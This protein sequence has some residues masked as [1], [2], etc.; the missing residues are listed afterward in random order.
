MKK[1]KNM[2]R[3]MLALSSMLILAISAP[4][5]MATVITYDFQGILGPI[6][7][8]IFADTETGLSATGDAISG[9]FSFDDGLK[10]SNASNGLDAYRSDFPNDP[11]DALAGGFSASITVGSVTRNHTVAAGGVSPAAQ[12]QV[13]D[14]ANQDRVLFSLGGLANNDPMLYLQAVDNAAA[15]PGDPDGVAAGSNNLMAGYNTIA[16]AG[17]LDILDNLDLSLFDTPFYSTWTQPNSVE[18]TGATGFSKVQFQWTGISRATADVP[19][20]ATL[21]LLGVGLFGLGF[22]RRKQR[23]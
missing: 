1:E 21:A 12:L 4:S 13:V 14:L 8:G 20:P 6:R 18:G 15:N 17:I 7:T 10:D 9:S 5:A 11:N 2:H 16:D 23:S 19:A 3:H 22:S